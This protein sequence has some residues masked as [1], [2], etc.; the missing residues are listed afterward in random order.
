MNRKN[1]SIALSRPI[2]VS[3]QE[4]F[5]GVEDDPEID[6]DMLQHYEKSEGN[7]M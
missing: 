5:V 2:N 1:R 4:E 7:D 3:S 6:G